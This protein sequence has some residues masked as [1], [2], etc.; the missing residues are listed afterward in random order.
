[1]TNPTPRRW[2]EAE[3]LRILIRLAPNVWSSDVL[4][5]RAAELRGREIQLMTAELGRGQEPTGAA[6]GKDDRD[7]IV[8]QAGEHGARRDLIIAHELGHLLL[9]HVDDLRAAGQVAGDV[10]LCRKRYSTDNERA[11]E[12]LATRLAAYRARSLDVDD[13]PAGRVSDFMR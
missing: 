9:G 2:T 6:I 1:M 11:A 5:Q 13:S 12:T 10:M 7:V 4:V 8:V 3:A